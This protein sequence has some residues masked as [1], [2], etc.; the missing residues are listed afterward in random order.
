MGEHKSATD[1]DDT[2]TLLAQA[3][4][5]VSLRITELRDDLKDMRKEQTGQGQR[6]AALDHFQSVV[7]D[8]LRGMDESMEVL[9]ERVPSSGAMQRLAKCAAGECHNMAK[10]S[11][12][13]KPKPWYT[14]P[15]MLPL[16]TLAVNVVVVIALVSALSGRKASDL[17][18]TVPSTPGKEA[19]P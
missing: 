15:I 10:L 11:A 7:L 12:E 8:R 1:S 3:L 2:P 13:E 17:V 16:A 4:R 5:G 6:L 19:K 18:P 9:A 14:Q